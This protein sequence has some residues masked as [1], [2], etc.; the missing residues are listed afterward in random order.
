[1]KNIDRVWELWPIS[2]LNATVRL[3]DFCF[4]LL[5]LFCWLCS[6]VSMFFIFLSQKFEA[7]VLDAKASKEQTLQELQQQR[8]QY[9]ELDLRTAELSKQLEAAKEAYAFPVLQ[10]LKLEWFGLELKFYSSL[11]W[12]LKIIDKSNIFSLLQEPIYIPP[13]FFYS[14]FRADSI[15]HVVSCESLLWFSTLL[16]FILCDCFQLN[17]WTVWSTE[18]Y[19]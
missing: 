6:D 11:L 9:T 19:L 10:D 12:F 5:F 7:D 14:V 18:A 1:M 3:D 2:T 8:Q 4:L 15:C 16:Q 17:S 13:V